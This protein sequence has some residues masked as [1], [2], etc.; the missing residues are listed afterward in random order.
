MSDLVMKIWN[1]EL[2]LAVHVKSPNGKWIVID[3]GSTEKFS[4]LQALGHSMIDYLVVT[5]PHLDHF[6]DIDN[7][8]SRRVCVLNA[9]RHYKRNELLDGVD[10]S[11][12]SK[13]E[14]YCD[15]VNNFAFPI[16]PEFDPRNKNAFGGLTTH[17]FRASNCDKANKN[18]HSAIVVLV[19]GKK[20]IVVCGDNEKESF[21][22]LMKDINFR[23]SVGQ[24]DILVAP[25]HGRESGFYESF[26]KIACPKLTII[27]DS[28]NVDTSAVSRYSSLSTGYRVFNMDN[29]SCEYRKCLTT[30]CDGDIVVAT[31]GIEM[32]VSNN[33]PRSFSR[34]YF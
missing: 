25:H 27:S 31:D 32:R 11:V 22:C 16:A 13:I 33:V 9:C 15:L 3:L 30:R 34:N 5:H 7:L 2:G 10:D 1:I 4:P 17:C 14:L 8:D 18:N 24:C 21:D 26:V 19:L 28:S 6:S 23:S 29:G 12:A 20:K